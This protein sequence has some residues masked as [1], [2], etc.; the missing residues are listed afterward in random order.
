[1]SPS[2]SATATEMSMW[3]QRRIASSLQEVVQLL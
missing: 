1:M 3:L 2:S